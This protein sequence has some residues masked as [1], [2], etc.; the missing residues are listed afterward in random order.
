M[1]KETPVSEVPAGVAPAVVVRTEDAILTMGYGKGRPTKSI[2]RRIWSDGMIDFNCA[3]CAFSADSVGSV[4]SH[5]STHK[6][7]IN[8]GNKRSK[9][10]L[11]PEEAEAKN[12]NNVLVAAISAVAAAEKALS[13][14]K[15]LLDVAQGEN[16]KDEEP[17]RTRALE[18]EKQLA[19]IK[20]MFSQ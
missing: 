13:R 14:A 2:R 6:T 17:W 11:T 7:Q 8:K 5:R 16:W 20:K 15:L 18:A 3:D 12:K 9:R 10:V 1:R 19:R 4:F